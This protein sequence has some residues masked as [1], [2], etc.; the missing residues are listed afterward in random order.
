MVSNIMSINIFR[1]YLISTYY[2]MQYNGWSS[3]ISYEK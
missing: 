1:Q 3:L 2:S